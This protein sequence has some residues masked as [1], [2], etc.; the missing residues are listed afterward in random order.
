MVMLTRALMDHIPPIFNVSTFREVVSNYKGTKSFKASMEHLDKSCRNIADA[1]L[2][3]HIRSQ[4]ILPN[5]TQVNF[6]N[7]LDVLLVE[8]VRNLS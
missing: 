5:R 7:D 4:E 2:H 1:S 6:A 3:V 8:I